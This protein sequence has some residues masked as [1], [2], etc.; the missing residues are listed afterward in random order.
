MRGVDTEGKGTS[1]NYLRHVRGGKFNFIVK[2]TVH[3]QE[4]TCR[5][6]G[7]TITFKTDVVNTGPPALVIEAVNAGKCTFDNIVIRRIEDQKK[8]PTK[9]TSILPK[10]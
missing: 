8:Q 2:L 9:K 5:V 10:V 3:G 4:V 1:A 6:D 7:K